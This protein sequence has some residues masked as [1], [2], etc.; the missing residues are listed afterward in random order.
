MHRVPASMDRCPMGFVEAAVRQ[1]RPSK[2][3]PCELTA[4]AKNVLELKFTQP[5]VLKKSN[6]KV[7]SLL[8]A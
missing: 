5:K 1:N 4:S 8:L 7:P 2:I 6:L 3:S